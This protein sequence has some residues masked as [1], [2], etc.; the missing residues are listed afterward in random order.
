MEKTGQLPA[1]QDL[2]KPA[3]FQA[4]RFTFPLGKRTYVMGILNVTPD[5]FS[6]GGKYLAS[7]Q[8]LRHAE[9]MLEQGADILDIGGESTRPGSMPVSCEEE[10]RRIIPVIDLIN[11]TFACP[12]SVDTYK[13]AVA[14]EALAAG[15]CILN[16]IN[17]LQLDST[18]AGIACRHR[19][20]VVIMHNARLYRTNEGQPPRQSDLMADILG[21]LQISVQLGMAAGLSHEQMLLDPGIGFGVTPDESIEMIARL[22]QLASLGLPILIGPSRKR[23]ISH[24]LGESATG[25]LFGTSAAIA[26]GIARGTDFVRVHDVREIVE[27]V[28]VADAIC[29]FGGTGKGAEDHG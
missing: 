29:R 8:A 3:V 12:I 16:D 17:G 1:R 22:D 24:I 27:V 20:G 28:R 2:C 11:R 10:Q 6:D 15:A 7:E 19:A 23:F 26:V 9:E 5:S 13:S 21:F 4:G 18:M 14:A 25:R